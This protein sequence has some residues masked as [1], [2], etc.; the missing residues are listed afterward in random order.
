MA[1][2]ED[3]FGTNTDL[4][5]E[6][7]WETFGDVAI[8][9][10]SAMAGNPE[11]VKAQERVFRSKR[12]LIEADALSIAQFQELTVKVYAEAIV[13]DWRNLTFKGEELPY[14]RENCVR[15]LTALP[16]LLDAIAKIANS[17]GTFQGRDLEAD[18]KN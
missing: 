18:A 16:A 10:A 4:E 11:F 15:V 7:V 1:S 14:S 2:L 9:I 6:G 17:R 12:R 5:R 3:M 8:R 13:K